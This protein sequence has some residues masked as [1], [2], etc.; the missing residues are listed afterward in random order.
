MTVAFESVTL[1]NF[2][3]FGKPQKIPLK[4]LGLVL[5]E[6]ENKK[7][8]SA[9]SNGAGKTNICEGIVWILFG[10]TTKNV[11][12][13][14]V[15]NNQ[16]D[17]NCRGVLEFSDSDGSQYV[18]TR[19]RKYKDIGNGL[20]FEK[21]L[22][23]GSTEDLS[24][25]DINSTQQ[26]IADFFGTSFNLFCTSTY[27]SQSSIKPFSLFTDKQ[28]KESFMEARD[29]G[30]FL[31]ALARAREELRKVEAS[32]ALLKGK[33]ERTDEEIKESQ[34]RLE[35]YEKE[36]ASFDATKAA[37]IKGLTDKIEGLKAKR[38]D[39]GKIG[40]EIL[41][42]REEMEK[43][44]VTLKTLPA[45]QEQLKKKLNEIRPLETNKHKLSAIHSRTVADRDS[46]L[47]RIKTAEKRIG[48]KCSECGKI[49]EASD[50]K[51]VIEALEKNAADLNAQIGKMGGLLARTEEALKKLSEEGK[52]YE[53]EIIR[54]K[55]LS[56]DAKEL[57]NQVVILQTQ[58]TNSKELEGMI[59]D[60]EAQKV[61][62]A[63]KSC[64][65]SPLIEAEKKNLIELGNIRKKQEGSQ[66]DQ[67]KEA[68]FIQYWVTA[69]GYSGIPSFLLES[70]ATFLNAQANHYAAVSCDSDINIQFQTTTKGKEK[71]AIDV[72]HIDGASR[73]A[74][75]S[76]GERKRADICIAQ[77]IQDMCRG[78]GKRPI[79]LVFY[80]EPFEHLDAEGI[81]GVMELL[82]DIT[83]KIGTVLVVTHDPELKSMFE[84]TIKVV[85]EA[86]GF[87]TVLM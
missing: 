23:D 31:D 33:V 61:T 42:R 80:D 49:I 37:A 59:A 62:E 24:G 76:G 82:Q 4:N 32:I 72:K 6:G 77:A 73:Y 85:K 78:Y 60:L 15:V 63:A 3:S 8:K 1:E 56:D 21:R 46:F 70:S 39:P 74:G 25:V 9:G 68:A 30:R 47:A 22:A 55:A 36:A 50:V 18:I 87:S 19:C 66:Q 20:I 75:I 7:S 16:V 5:I 67:I 43:I 51:H 54:I 28:I 53:D 17:K 38:I 40:A 48:T 57:S 26:I 35:K 83:K 64:S 27:F 41:K 86:D 71:F 14:D 44:E 84:K 81:A 58:I 69:F 65:L 34:E 11:A 2:M 79:D 29:L 52:T 12:A 13:G 10:Q 45:V